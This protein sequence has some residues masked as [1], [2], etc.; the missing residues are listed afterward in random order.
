LT[1]SLYYILVGHVSILLQSLLITKEVIVYSVKIFFVIVLA[2]ILSCTTEVVSKPPPNAY[3]VVPF[4]ETS[5]VANKGDAADDPAIWIHPNDISKSLVIGTDKGFGLEVYDLNGLRVQSIAAGRT[6]NVDLRYLSGND[7]WSAFAAA[8]NRTTNTISLFAISVG[9]AVKWLQDSEVVTGLSEPYGLC[10]FHNADGFQVFVNDTD[11]RY[12][13][14]G[15][16]E[17]DGSFESDFPRLS[18][19]LLREFS[20]PSQPEGCVVDDENE[21]LFLGV[22]AEGV[23]MIDANSTTPAELNMI[24]DIDGIILAA[25]VEGMTLYKDGPEGYLIVSSQG[26]YSYAIFDRLPPFA[27]RGS[28]VVVDNALVGVD[29]SQE[30]DG[31]A[32]SSE[33]RTSDFPSGLLVVQDGYNTLPVQ[34]QNFKY[35]SW[36]EIQDALSL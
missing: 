9:G 1:E 4:A 16:A 8:S 18:A 24:A 19:S 28:F 5:P 22:E 32:I 25:D 30:T 27:Y 23:R 20:V 12:Q 35:I 31:L 36:K 7:R 2:N 11:G 15:L 26:N 33:L 21:R 6:N 3:T 29:G 13:Q 10:M 14:W 34:A 17:I